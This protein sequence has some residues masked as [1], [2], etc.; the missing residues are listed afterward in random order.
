MRT[1]NAFMPMIGLLI[2]AGCA[3]KENSLIPQ[4]IEVDQ[5]KPATSRQLLQALNKGILPKMT[6]DKLPPR[7]KVR[8]LLA[9]YK[10]LETSPSGK[11]I[12]WQNPSGTYSGSV[13]A[14][15]PYKVGSQNCRQYSHSINILGQ[16]IKASGAACRSPNGKWVPIS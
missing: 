9:E 7:D 14:L 16:Q 12:V 8:A 5:I 15:Q 10:A 6:F 11:A 13:I 2:L 3:P 1:A 4:R